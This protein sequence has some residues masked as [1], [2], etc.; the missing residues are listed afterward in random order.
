MPAHRERS[1]LREVLESRPNHF[2]AM[3]LVFSFAV[4]FG[5]SFVIAA[6][7]SMEHPW[8]DATG[9][10]IYRLTR[11]QLFSGTLGVDFFFLISGYLVTR[12]WQRA[13]GAGNYALRRA[14]RIYPAFLVVVCVGAFLVGPWSIGPERYFQRFHLGAFVQSALLLQQPVMPKV[15]VHNPLP[16]EP[17]GSL[18]TIRYEATCYLMV[19]LLGWLGAYRRPWVVLGLFLG[20]LALAFTQANFFPNMLSY[21][22]EIYPFGMPGMWPNLL[23]FFLAGMVLCLYAER[24]PYDRRLAGLAVAAL[25]LA[26]FDGA[27]LILPVFGAYLVFYLALQP[28][29]ALDALTR[30]GDLSYGVYLYAFLIQQTWMQA[31]PQVFVHSPY[32]LFA[33]TVPPTLACAFLSWHGV[34]KRPLRWKR[35]RLER[36]EALQGAVRSA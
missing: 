25:A 10:W 21:T 20:S 12:S 5:H 33:A 26:C 23:C 1:S 35:R 29:P 32:R 16:N 27:E 22:R 11:G 30:R 3:R 4:V 15:F 2:D 28:A 6:G 7:N 14:L 9:D 34:E 24:I 18:W 8:G 17:N 19:A 36:A 31:F 13:P